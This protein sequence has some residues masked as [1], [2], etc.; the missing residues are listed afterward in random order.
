MPAFAWHSRSTVL[1]HATA[2]LRSVFARDLSIPVPHDA[3]CCWLAPTG[4]MTGAPKLRSV[5]ILECL[6]EGPRGVYS[7]AMG[8]LGL[9][10]SADL[11]VVI[12]TVFIKDDR[13]L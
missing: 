7:G 13:M 8:F 1:M 9:N 3:L 12:R 2:W 4:S 11:N 10:G 5:H 6:E